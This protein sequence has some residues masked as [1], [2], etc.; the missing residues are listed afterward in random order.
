MCDTEEH[1]SIERK[2]K[3]DG[4]TWMVRYTRSTRR[5]VNRNGKVKLKS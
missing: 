2:R 1:G 4:R 5:L 3:E